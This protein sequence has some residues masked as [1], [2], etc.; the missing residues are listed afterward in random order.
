[1]YKDVIEVTVLAYGGV[2]IMKGIIVDVK[3]IA[4]MS[5]GGGVDV[6]PFLVSRNTLGNGEPQL[7]ISNKIVKIGLCWWKCMV[8]VDEEAIVPK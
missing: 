1:M 3:S 6:K 2:K 8:V 4:M 5:G 7:K